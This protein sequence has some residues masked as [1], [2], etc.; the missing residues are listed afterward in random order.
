TGDFATMVS[1]RFG[2]GE[3]CRYFVHK[4]NKDS[5]R[6]RVWSSFEDSGTENLKWIQIAM[7]F[8]LS[9]G[10]P[11]FYFWLRSQLF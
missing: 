11:S 3:D 7:G 8:R 10:R 9:G 6:G 2:G 5:R 4:N 1:E